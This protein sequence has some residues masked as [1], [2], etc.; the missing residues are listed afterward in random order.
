M[1]KVNTIGI[2][3]YCNMLQIKN[4]FNGVTYKKKGI[5]SLTAL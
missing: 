1:S 3:L 4:L 5:S 2:V